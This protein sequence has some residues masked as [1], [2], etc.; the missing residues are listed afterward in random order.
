[1]ILRGIGGFI[2]GLV[3]AF[4]LV[5]AA[6]FG[7]HLLY[8]S[9]PG[10]N[11]RDMKAIKTFVATLP[12]PAFILVLV[13]WLVATFAGAFLAARIGRSMIP[14]YILGVVL[15]AGG[16]ANAIIIPQPVWFSAASFVIYIG[17]TIVGSKLGRPAVP[18]PA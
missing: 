1:M 17:M 14:G 4:L 15:L 9:P 16:I 7:V 13:G 6:E 2:A 12:M 5:Q 10:T 3:L 11:M 8:P 18:S